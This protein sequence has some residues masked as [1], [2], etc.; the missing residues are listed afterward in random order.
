LDFLLSLS[1]SPKR[2]RDTLSIVTPVFTYSL[3]NTNDTWWMASKIGGK[4]EG[5]RLQYL[6]L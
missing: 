5:K 3:G 6:F 4:T 1:L 2:L